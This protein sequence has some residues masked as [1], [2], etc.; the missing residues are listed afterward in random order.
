L[1][2]RVGNSFRPYNI[3]QLHT[4]D[5]A[6]ANAGFSKLK[7]ASERERAKLRSP[8]GGFE[9]PPVDGGGIA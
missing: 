3:E 4:D 5:R 2:I 1:T 7:I 9:I 8:T 6:Q